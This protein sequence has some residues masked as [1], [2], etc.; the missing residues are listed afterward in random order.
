[1]SLT[2]LWIA[3]GDL[4]IV[5]AMLSASGQPAKCWRSCMTS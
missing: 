1:M 3:V 4:L 2:T 5:A